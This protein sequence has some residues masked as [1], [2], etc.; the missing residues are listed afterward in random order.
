MIF[1]AV[2]L[3]VGILVWVMSW[4]KSTKSTKSNDVIE[5]LEVVQPVAEDVMVNHLEEVVEYSIDTLV[6]PSGKYYVVYPVGKELISVRDTESGEIIGEAYS[7]LAGIYDSSN[8]KQ[9]RTFMPEDE[10]EFYE[11]VENQEYMYNC[12]GCDGNQGFLTVTNFKDPSK[13]F[14]DEYFH[15]VRI[16][17]TG[18]YLAY[19]PGIWLWDDYHRSENGGLS[20]K[21]LIDPNTAPRRPDVIVFDTKIAAIV[22]WAGVNLA[23]YA[24]SEHHGFCVFDFISDSNDEYLLVSYENVSALAVYETNTWQLINTIP[25]SHSYN[26]SDGFDLELENGCIWDEETKKYY[27]LD[28]RR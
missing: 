20:D 7:C 4:P 26:Y 21:K 17:R 28:P 18:R 1:I 5:N 9:Y 2:C 6:S 3:L 22:L 8:G 25:V 15:S 19:D 16:S 14:Y 12:F 23:A 24:N 27:K 10:L 13:D 11:F